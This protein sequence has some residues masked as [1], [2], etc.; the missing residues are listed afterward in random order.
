MAREWA[1]AGF[2][3]NKESVEPDAA[4][5]TPTK[6]HRRTA[7]GRRSRIGSAAKLLLRKFKGRCRPQLA[8][9]WEAET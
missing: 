8:V 2:P 9:F 1:L 7:P 5:E 3:K 6:G 4:Q